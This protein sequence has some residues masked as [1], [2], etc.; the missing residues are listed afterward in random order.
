MRFIIILCLLLTQ[1]V[2]SS[3]KKEINLPNIQVILDKQQ[4][5]IK[6]N[7]NLFEKK[8]MNRLLSSETITKNLKFSFP[9]EINNTLKVIDKYLE[10]K[11][12][13]SGYLNAL[14]LYIE[15]ATAY[16]QNTNPKKEFENNIKV[17]RE[18]FAGAKQSKTP[19]AS[20][21]T[22][23]L[24]SISNNFKNTVEAYAGEINTPTALKILRKYKDSISKY[25]NI[26]DLFH[27]NG[28]RLNI[29]IP[30]PIAQMQIQHVVF[31]QKK[32]A[33]HLIWEDIGV[34]EN[35]FYNPEKIKDLQ[36]NANTVIKITR[37]APN[38]SDFEKFNK[39]INFFP[40]RLI[41]QNE[42]NQKLYDTIKAYNK[43]PKTDRLLKNKRV[44]FL[45]SIAEEAQKL[46]D[47]LEK[48]KSS[49]LGTQ[50]VEAN[51]NVQQEL[52]KEIIL[53]AKS[54]SNYILAIDN[55]SE[56][57]IT[58]LFTIPQNKK[59][60]AVVSMKEGTLPH[61]IPRSYNIE[62]LRDNDPGKRNYK[63]HEGWLRKWI[64]STAN[65]E[66]PPSY[67]WWLEGQDIGSA[68]PENAPDKES[69]KIVIENGILMSQAYKENET[70]CSQKK[71]SFCILK[72]GPYIFAITEKEELL[73]APREQDRLHHDRL[74]EGENLILAGTMTVG[75]GKIVR[76]DNFSGHY[77]PRVYPHLING[78]KIL[79]NLNT[80]SKNCI[81]SD[82]SNFLGQHGL[83]VNEFRILAKVNL[84]KIVQSS[85][86]E[87]II[88]L[89]I[90]KKR[91]AEERRAEEES[92]IK[93]ER[94]DYYQPTNI[95]IKKLKPEQ[96]TEEEQK[97]ARTIQ[98]GFRERK[99]QKLQK[100]LDVLG[101]PTTDNQN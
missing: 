80:F 55:I 67:F 38:Q 6:L 11:S 95:E 100:K 21:R 33:I 26:L 85:S 84:G 22:K 58:K 37:T 93:K 91:S 18:Q 14:N 2:Y 54:K 97:A 19:S 57:A 9:E 64:N 12:D 17:I 46:L 81:I 98:K 78:F 76:F 49:I 8:Y 68:L 24:K 89:A 73:I 70:V 4:K 40:T 72:P 35:Y 71:P 65:Q 69:M 3:E 28:F 7:M 82:S 43:V 31:L 44:E 16:I 41:P 61:Q 29:V 45:I 86:K 25:K 75:G 32:T 47:Q 79:D 23:R 101:K 87:K 50:E 60:I 92:K 74:A 99:T 88:E 96:F 34:P 90:Q 51:F 62:W 48:E 39:I 53:T 77:R 63:F 66:N 10:G 52:Y 15:K 30:F 13:F 36:K 56:K 27:N 83:S 1:P 59:G 5:S 94:G 20:Y 42:S